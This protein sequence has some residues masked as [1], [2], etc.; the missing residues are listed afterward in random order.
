LITLNGV[1]CKEQAVKMLGGLLI[2]IF[3]GSLM[4]ITALLAG[5]GFWWSLLIY[6]MSGVCI[7]L[8]AAAYTVLRGTGATRASREIPSFDPHPVRGM[9]VASVPALTPV[10]S[11]R[12]VR[13]N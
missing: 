1:G 4:G 3:A 7:F 10:R 5:F 12:A 2:S 6:S 13:K 9:Q 8:V 11:V